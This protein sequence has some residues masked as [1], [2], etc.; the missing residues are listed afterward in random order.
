MINKRSIS[1]ALPG[2]VSKMVPSGG[3]HLEA[4]GAE[5]EDLYILYYSI[6]ASLFGSFHRKNEKKLGN[7]SLKNSLFKK[8]L[9]KSNSFG[10]GA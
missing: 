9:P 2:A 3:F 10:D 8:N 5:Q 4:A 1:P 6:C 7:T